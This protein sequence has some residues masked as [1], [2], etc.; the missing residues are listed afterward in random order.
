MEEVTL[1]KN[2]MDTY[3]MT[4]KYD[5]LFDLPNDPEERDR[6]VPRMVLEKLE[7]HEFE[8]VDFNLTEN[9]GD[10]NAKAYIDDPQ[11]H[12]AVL[13]IRLNLSMRALK[14]RDAIYDCCI[15]AFEQDKLC[16]ERAY[17]NENKKLG[18]LQSIIVF[19]MKRQRTVSA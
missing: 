10:D 6:E 9:Y 18:M 12:R 1:I 13:E 16:L 8:L 15:K 2:V 17:E 5:G 11:L 14:S 19:D 7:Q 4:F 3:T